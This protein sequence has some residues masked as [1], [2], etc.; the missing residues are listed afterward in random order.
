MVEISNS[1]VYGLP[2]E[3]FFIPFLMGNTLIFGPSSLEKGT[4]KLPVSVDQYV[5]KSGG[6][7]SVCLINNS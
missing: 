6:L 1:W 7:L 3:K 5:S 2:T 4:A